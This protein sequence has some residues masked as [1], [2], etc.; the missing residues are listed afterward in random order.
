MNAPNTISLEEI[1]KAFQLHFESGFAKVAALKAM[2]KKMK[3]GKIS[4]QLRMGFGYGLKVHS[5]QV[6]L[7]P[8]IEQDTTFMINQ[9]G[10][11]SGPS[12]SKAMATEV[13]TEPEAPVVSGEVQPRES[14]SISRTLEGLA[15]GS[16]DTENAD[17]DL[18]E[19]LNRILGDSYFR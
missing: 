6:S 4:P 1:I 11:S 2:D 12:S 7:V 8:P 13:S 15:Y 3:T 10:P 18:E 16:V 9:P 17:Y 19:K 5:S 14:S